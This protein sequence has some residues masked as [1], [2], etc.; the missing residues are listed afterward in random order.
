M[1]VKKTEWRLEVETHGI[2]TDT[3][4][5]EIESSVRLS[6]PSVCPSSSKSIWLFF[7]NTFYT[8]TKRVFRIRNKVKPMFGRESVTTKPLLL[9][10]LGW[11][12]RHMSSKKPIT[13]D[14]K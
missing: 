9:I 8:K 7:L 4:L 6:S 5:S 10:I 3:L 12:P 2:S 11:F 13:G 14:Y 1:T